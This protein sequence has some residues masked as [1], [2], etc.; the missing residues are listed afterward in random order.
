MKKIISLLM[1]LVFLMS[2]AMSV[3]ASDGD[4]GLSSIGTQ[5]N[6]IYLD[7]KSKQSFAEE[8]D[9]VYEVALEKN[10]IFEVSNDIVEQLMVRAAFADG[11][12]KI[13]L[14]EQLEA[15]G[16]YQ[17]NENIN[18]ELYSDSSDVTINAP[19]IFYSASANTWTVSCQGSWKNSNWNTGETGNVGGYD[20]FGVAYTRASGYNTSVVGSSAYIADQNGNSMKKTSNRSDGNGALGFGFQLQDYVSGTRYIGYR[21]YG[22]CTYGSNFANFS[23]TATAYYAHTYKTAYINNITFTGGLQPGV[24]IGIANQSNAFKVYSTDTRF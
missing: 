23:G 8:M 18:A 10:E 9:R 20:A 22:S 13:A 11:D 14:L 5:N 7:A 12:E 6:G 24:T 15:Y 16:I 3:S 17:Y 1:S 4:V 19:N 2:C 21:W